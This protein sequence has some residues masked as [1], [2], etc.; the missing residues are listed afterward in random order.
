MKDPFD[1]YIK[2]GAEAVR[3]SIDNAW[4]VENWMRLA[5]YVA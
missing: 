5:E 3:A 2:Y 4:I 1:L